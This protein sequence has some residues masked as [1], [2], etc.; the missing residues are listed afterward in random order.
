[1][2]HAPLAVGLLWLGQPRLPSCDWPMVLDTAASSLA[3]SLLVWI[4][5]VRPAVAI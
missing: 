2:A 4:I 3:R 1:V 5:L